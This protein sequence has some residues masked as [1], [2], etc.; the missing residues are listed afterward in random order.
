MKADLVLNKIKYRRD[1]KG[2][3]KW[4]IIADQAKMFEA[5]QK[6]VFD[7]PVIYFFNNKNGQVIA[8]AKS[9]VYMISSEIIDLKGR[10]VIRTSD[11]SSLHSELLHFKQKDMVVDTEKAVHIN[12]KDGLTIDGKGLK[13]NIST[14]KLTIFHSTAI[15]PEHRDGELL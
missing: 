1:E 7:K 11:A 3:K 14:G 9:G 15:I 6:I 8:S 5:N 2:K 13:Y 12:R 4:T 10:V